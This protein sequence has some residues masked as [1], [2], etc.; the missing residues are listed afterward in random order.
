ML[1]A[2]SKPTYTYSS[3]QYAMYCFFGFLL[4]ILLGVLFSLV[5]TAEYPIEIKMV[6]PMKKITV[7]VFYS[8]L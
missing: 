2:I 5:H 6:A 8:L 4:Y 3:L 7:S 1:S